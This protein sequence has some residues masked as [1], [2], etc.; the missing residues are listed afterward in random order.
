MK[1]A[2]ELL[3]VLDKFL[4]TQAD[5]LSRPEVIAECG[6]EAA[7]LALCGL[8]LQRIAHFLRDLRRTA[9]AGGDTEMLRQLD[10]IDHP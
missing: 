7:M 6:E 5:V 10:G 4:G 9:E 8:Q 3:E 1:T 2:P